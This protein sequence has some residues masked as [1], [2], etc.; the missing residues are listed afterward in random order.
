VLAKA[1]ELV[2]VARKYGYRPE[3]LAEIIKQVS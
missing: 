2:E 3:E 1:R